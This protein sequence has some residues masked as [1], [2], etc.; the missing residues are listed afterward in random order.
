MPNKCEHLKP[1]IECVFWKPKRGCTYAGGGCSPVVDSCE[2]C[3][4]VGTFPAGR[5]CTVYADPAY[6]WSVG[7]CNFATH[8]KSDVVQE[9]R[10][11]NPLKASKRAARGR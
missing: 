5:Y 7:A 3:E 8:V 11:L 2:G 4:H 10:K 6:K 9:A 1:G